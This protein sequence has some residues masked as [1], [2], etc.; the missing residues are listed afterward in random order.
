MTIIAWD[1][2]TIAADRQATTGDMRVSVSK[3]NRL[4]NGEIVAFSGFVPLGQRL[5][6][7]YSAGADPAQ[8]PAF[9][10]DDFARLIVLGAD[11]LRSYERVPH[12]MACE[13]PFAAFGDGRDFA[14]GAMRMGADAAHAVKIACE[15][16]IYCGLGCDT[17]TYEAPPAE[18]P[19]DP[20]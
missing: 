7:W 13:D 2:K 9:T 16:S 18:P 19:V 20:R 15:F 1:G 11:G 12:A 4:P 10:G 5:L 3:L 17:M 14:I 8:F 6:A